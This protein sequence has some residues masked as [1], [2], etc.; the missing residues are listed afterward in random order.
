MGSTEV[1]NKLRWQIARLVDFK[2]S[3]YNDNSFW[4]LFWTLPTSMDDIITVFIPS[5]I[6][7]IRDVNIKAFAKLI[8]ETSYRLIYLT[9]QKNVKINEFP[10]VQLL[11]CIRLLTVLLPFLYEKPSINYIEEEIFWK[12]IYHPLFYPDDPFNTNSCNGTVGTNDSLI[13]VDDSSSKESTKVNFEKMIHTDKLVGVELVEGCL[14]LLFT[15]NFTIESSNNQ[16]R[17]SSTYA[18]D[19]LLIPWEAGVQA[20]GHYRNP[21]L[22]LDSNRLELLRLMISLFSKNL[23][24]QVSNVTNEGSKFLTT[25][26]TITDGKM[27]FNL[28]VSLLNATLRTLRDPSLTNSTDK[29]INVDGDNVNGLD[30]ADTLHKKV[31]ILMATNAIDL[32]T[33][34]I[35]YSIPKSHIVFLQKHHL[36]TSHSIRNRARMFLNI[37][38]EKQDISLIIHSLIFPLLKSVDSIDFGAF[39]S[40]MKSS[41]IM[42]NDEIHVWATEIMI[43]ILEFYQCNAKFRGYFAEIIGAKYL[44]VLTYYVMKYSSNKNYS[45]FVKLCIT[46]LLFFSAD[47]RIGMKLLCSLD[48][49]FYDTLPQIAKTS[50]IPASYRDYIII[51]ICNYIGKKELEECVFQ[52]TEILH[53][54]ICLNIMLLEY[55]KKEKEEVLTNRRLSIKE[56]TKSHPTQLSYVASTSILHLILK[57]TSSSYFEKDT[58]TNADHSS[59]I[60]RAC[61]QALVRDP[62]GSIL[63]LYVFVKNSNTFDKIRTNLKKISNDMY[64]RLIQQEVKDYHRRVNEIEQQ[65]NNQTVSSSNAL[66]KVDEEFRKRGELDSF[67]MPVLSRQSTQN[68]LE[69]TPSSKSMP[70]ISRQT[71]QL[72]ISN[73]SPAIRQSSFSPDESIDPMVSQSSQ[74]NSLDLHLHSVSDGLNS[75]VGVILDD[76]RVFNSERPIGMS[77]KRKD[78]QP[79]YRRFYERW[80]GNESLTLIE[81]V[82]KV[83]KDVIFVQI[84]QNEFDQLSD[85]SHTVQRISRL[86]L[87]EMF[88]TLDKSILFDK[89]HTNYEPI[90]IKWSALLLGWYFSLIWADIFQN[91]SVHLAK[92]LLAGISSS[93]TAI[94]KVSSS[95]GFGSWKLGSLV[96]NSSFSIEIE[97]ESRIYPTDVYYDNILRNSIWFGTHIVLFRVNAQVFKEHY[98]LQHGKAELSQINTSLGNNSSNSFVNEIFIKRN[99]LSSPIMSVKNGSGVF[100]EGFWKRQGG[101]PTSLDRRD[102]DGSLKLQLSKGNNNK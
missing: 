31:R 15:L 41:N 61:A 59:L 18:N 58:E 40:I 28:C 68:T 8:Q 9:K 77:K 71:S 21:K 91:Y 60:L 2:D 95:W 102:S 67:E 90:K 26:V 55:H 66:D 42:D 74:K 38:Q 78:K 69:S 76:E 50:N 24:S 1:K 53:N 72:S 57:F 98:N 89:N 65:E 27:F 22:A 97:K 62:Y 75:D 39:S 20:P 5:N 83:V 52:L 101:R 56:I 64:A 51:Q 25:L 84:N 3:Y 30:I 19:C 80:S 6:R 49:N 4:T 32:L 45:S 48:M 17:K 73:G 94:K 63:L 46:N 43:L 93:F 7:Y 13:D 10:T 85:A 87:N 37:I 36:V 81:D 47:L 96:D 12:Q 14:N 23:Y 29:I 54:M 35:V 70:P 88:E 11:N 44:I 34:L 92:G 99:S 79:Y 16:K 100:T 33:L 82:L 86:N